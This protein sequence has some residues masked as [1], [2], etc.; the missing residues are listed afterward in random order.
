MEDF[1]KKAHWE[2]IYGTK[3]LNEVSWY[4]PVPEISLDFIHKFNLSKDA[5]IIDIGGGD[6]FLA[7]S[8]LKEGY[9]DITV[10]DISEAAL[11]RA[12]ARLGDKANKIHWIVDD[13]SAF[14]AERQYDFWHDRAAFHFLNTKPEVDSY[15]ANAA[16]AIVAG[17]IAVI[18]TFSENGPKKCSGIEI[19]QYS[20]EG[21]AQ[22]FQKGFEVIECFNTDHK[23]PFDMIQN[24]TFCSFRKK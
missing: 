23:T 16:N 6:S 4:Q 5:A 2:N 1:N 7:D 12:K 14:K 18:G 3:Q 15:I 9:T 8:L 11:E 22:Q 10:L 19:T 21:L 17:G 13:A 24:F 20:K